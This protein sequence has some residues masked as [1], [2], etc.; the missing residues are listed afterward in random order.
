MLGLP[1]IGALSYH[2]MTALW[3]FHHEY[4]SFSFPNFASCRFVVLC[5]AVP[6]WPKHVSYPENLLFY[7]FFSPFHSRLIVLAILFTPL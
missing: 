6:F 5:R 7:W 1:D 4:K 2:A 3:H